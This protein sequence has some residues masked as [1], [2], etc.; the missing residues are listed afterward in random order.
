MIKKKEY[1]HSVNTLKNILQMCDP[2]SNGYKELERISNASKK[3][4]QTVALRTEFNK[5]WE[6]LGI[7]TSVTYFQKLATPNP[8]L[9]N[10]VEIHNALIDLHREITSNKHK[11]KIKYFENWDD[12][13]KATLCEDIIQSRIDVLRKISANQRHNIITTIHTSDLPKKFQSYQQNFTQLLIS[14]T[15]LVNDSTLSLPKCLKKLPSDYMA[16]KQQ[17]L[18]IHRLDFLAGLRLLS[19]LLEKFDLRIKKEHL[20]MLSL[21][22]IF[23]NG[24]S[25]L[26]IGEKNIMIL[27]APILKIETLVSQDQWAPTLRLHSTTGPA[28]YTDNTKNMH[29]LHGVYVDS[30]TWKKTME[31]MI[32]VEEIMAIRNIEQRRVVIQHIGAEI[33]SKHEKAIEGKISPNGNQLIRLV[34]L[35]TKENTPDLDDDDKLDVLMV[36]YKDPSTGREYHSFVPPT[37]DADDRESKPRTDP[38]EAMAWKFGMSKSDY[39]NK[40]RAQA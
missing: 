15:Q 18:A 26:A 11:V 39:Y 1:T 27:K 9:K 40:M 17:V 38:D 10:K 36:K 31:K 20:L 7:D 8:Y 3:D 22:K 19:L 6:L 14:P 24:I 23:E 28:Y 37:L 13:I 30:P 12:F 34:G 25:H 32:T 33:F 35:L 16:D 4:K 5:Q 29:Y 2:N 21:A